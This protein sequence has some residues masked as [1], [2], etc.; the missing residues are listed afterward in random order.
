[1]TWR[2]REVREKNKSTSEKVREKRRNGQ[3][4]RKRWQ[5]ERVK[6]GHEKGKIRLGGI[7]GE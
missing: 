3:A 1:M 6:E 2:Y 5:E 4:G 7:A